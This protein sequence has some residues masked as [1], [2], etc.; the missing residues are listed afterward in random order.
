MHY[1]KVK[2]GIMKHNR[3]RREMQLRGKYSFRPFF[4]FPIIKREFFIL[5][6]V[7]RLDNSTREGYIISQNFRQ[8]YGTAISS[9]G[10][11]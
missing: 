11:P 7:S 2:S 1:E 5:F 10:P 3:K 4:K 6:R 9:Y 8:K